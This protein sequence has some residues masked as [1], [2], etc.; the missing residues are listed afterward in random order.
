MDP[1]TRMVKRPINVPLK[2]ALPLLCICVIVL[3]CVGITGCLLWG[4][5]G[6]KETT[7]K[8]VGVS[9]TTGEKVTLDST[10]HVDG[11]RT[12]DGHTGMG[13]TWIKEFDKNG[14]LKSIR[15]DDGVTT[16]GQSYD[17]PIDDPHPGLQQGYHLIDQAQNTEVQ[18]TQT[19]DTTPEEQAAVP[20]APHSDATAGHS[21]TTP[22]EQ[23]A[24]P[25]AYPTG[26]P[27][28]PVR[29][30]GDLTDILT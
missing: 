11:T 29:L 4:N 12:E 8:A 22:E 1:I 17:H 24:V 25:T 23:A 30:P 5:T 10:T 9:Q 7:T 13:R 28:G 20:T 6:G 14:R 26:V 18:P 15:W 3:A 21:D 19:P 2:K 27:G 16:G